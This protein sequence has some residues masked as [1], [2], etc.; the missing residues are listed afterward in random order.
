MVKIK[1]YTFLRLY[2]VAMAMAAKECFG[3][4]FLH[5]SIPLEC[6]LNTGFTACFRV[7]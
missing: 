7:Q 6:P 5:Y 3:K 4:A 1:P 2:R